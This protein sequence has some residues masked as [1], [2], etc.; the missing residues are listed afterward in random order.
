M[1]SHQ[2][3]LSCFIQ[4][5]K[6]FYPALVGK[7]NIVISMSVGDLSVGDLSAYLRNYICK[8]HHISVHITC[9]VLPVLWMTSYF[10]HG[11]DE[12]RLSKV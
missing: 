7:R 5:L 3:Q 12:V 8:L 1:C 4:V 6:D 2:A 9:C 11:A 10:P